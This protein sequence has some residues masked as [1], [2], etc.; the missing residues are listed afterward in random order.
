MSTNPQKDIRDLQRELDNEQGQARKAIVKTT[1]KSPK[2][3]KSGSFDAIAV[4][5]I[6]LVVFSHQVIQ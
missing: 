1:G 5:V 4:A 3:Q 6:G 2:V